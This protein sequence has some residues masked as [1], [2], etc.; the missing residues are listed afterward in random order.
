MIQQK[1]IVLFGGQSGEH[2]V[3]LNSA[4]SVL[5]AIDKERYAVETIGITKSGQWHWGIKPEDW[6]Q[7]PDKKGVPV[8]L[9]H[10]PINP[11]FLALDGS[12]LPGDGKFD[13]IFPVLHGPYGEDGTLQGL[14]E[15]ANVPYVGS[16]VLGSALGMDKDRMKAVF[17]QA[18]LPQ[19]A[20]ITVLRSRLKEN[21][22]G[23]LKDIEE[24]IGYPCFVKPANLGSSVGI[25]KA[26]NQEELMAAL[27]LAAEYDRKLVIE[28]NIVGREIELSV[29]GNED[30]KASIPGEILP[31]KE[32]YDYEAKYIDTGS[33]LVIPAPLE[34]EVVKN[35][36]AIAVKAFKAVEAC[37]LSR[38]DFFVTKDNQIFINEINTMPGFTNISMY[39]K[40]WAAS[41]IPYSELITKLIELGFERFQDS[42]SRKISR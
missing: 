36:Q 19:A 29:L 39:P 7:D 31:A 13:L 18:G 37:G 3:S 27:N 4:S 24:A 16:G 28:Q 5:K 42:R 25:S 30:P 34:P 32:F 2:E 1:I 33:Q 8:V 21:P 35:L 41:G 15:M 10:D 23:V 22:S 20:Y 12:P 11:R 17:A 6:Q 38:V 40:L 9:V 14:L 26:N